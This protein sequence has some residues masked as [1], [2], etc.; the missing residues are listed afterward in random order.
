[1]IIKCKAVLINRLMIRMA[2][3]GGITVFVLFLTLSG[4]WDYISIYILSMAILTPMVVYVFYLNRFE[5]VVV[6]VEN[7][8]VHLS[9]VNNSIYK[10]KDIKIAKDNIVVEQKGDKLLFTINGEL[11]AV[12]RKEA[13]E[14]T[15]WE[16]AVRTFTKF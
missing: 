11:R 7:N 5:L 16:R 2:I 10:R 3:I 6:G 9:F 15:D 13:V 14:G 4:K 12:L 8:I 1:M